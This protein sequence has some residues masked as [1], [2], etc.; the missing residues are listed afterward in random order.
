MLDL[1][2]I[3]GLCLFF[4]K[5]KR[6]VVAKQRW[7]ESDAVQRQRTV[8]NECGFRVVGRLLGACALVIGGFT[9]VSP[10]LGVIWGLVALRV[11][12]PIQAEMRQACEFRSTGASDEIPYSW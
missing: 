4:A 5:L 9:V 7:R 6:T 11:I 1:L 3:G 10:S 8:R 12:K 2:V